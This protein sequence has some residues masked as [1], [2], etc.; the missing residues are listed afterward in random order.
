METR[1]LMKCGHVAQA[2]DQHDHP[3]CAICAGI[4]PAAFEVER[5]LTHPTDGLEGR[6]AECPY[7]GRTTDS[8]WTLP[9]F[10]YRP[11]KETDSYYCGCFGWD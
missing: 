2:K 8:R 5:E 6:K 1:H 10:E 7:C 3:C 11:D 9:F 4:T